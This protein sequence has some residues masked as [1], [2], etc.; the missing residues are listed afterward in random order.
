[1]T[2]DQ[3]PSVGRDELIA[4]LLQGLENIPDNALVALGE[5]VDDDVSSAVPLGELR[6]S[7]RAKA[8]EE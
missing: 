6:A 3:Q 7:L 5:C 2:K 8:V 1:M 4:R